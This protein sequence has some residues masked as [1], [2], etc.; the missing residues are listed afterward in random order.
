MFHVFKYRSLFPRSVKMAVFSRQ[1][2][3]TAL[4]NSVLSAFNRSFKTFS[5]AFSLWL[6]KIEAIKLCHFSWPYFHKM[7][8]SYRKL[9][10]V[11]V[12]LFEKFRL[13]FHEVKNFYSF[14]SLEISNLLFF[15]QHCVFSFLCCAGF[16]L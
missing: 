2:S 9:T 13:N 15:S 6:L 1:K 10:I 3:Q 14:T 5:R 8:R 12:L 11:N 16:S 7:M 4:S